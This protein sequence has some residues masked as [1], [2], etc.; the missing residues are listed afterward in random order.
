MNEQALQ[1]YEALY[2]EFPDKAEVHIAL[3]QIANQINTKNFAD[4]RMLFGTGQ[5]QSALDVLAKAEN[6]SSRY[7]WLDINTP[8]L[9]SGLRSEIQTAMAADYFAKA[10]DAVENEMWDQASTYIYKARR[11]GSDKA[12]LEYLELM[13]EIVPRYKKGLK[14]KELGLY[15]D[16]FFYF[17]EVAEIDADFDQ[18]LDHLEYC[19]ERAEMTLS[20]IHLLE[21]RGVKN[22]DKSIIASVQEEILELNNP[23]VRLVTR[24]DMDILLQEQ[25]NAMEAGFDDR[26]MIEAGLLLGAKYLIVGE[27]L[28]NKFE[29]DPL[30]KV[31]K[32]GYDGQTVLA[33]K[34]EY[35]ENSITSR[36]IVS[37]RYRVLNAET[38]EILAAENIPYKYE[39][40]VK[41]I[42]YNGDPSRLK[43]GDWKFK[44]FDSA[45]DRIFEEDPSESDL[46]ALAN[47]RKTP[48]SNQELEQKFIKY[49][50]EVI[51]SKVDAY[52]KNRSL[53]DPND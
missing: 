4:A 18:V 46:S 27:V 21:G 48:L 30:R 11:A 26:E 19:R 25:R 1:A 3:K 34:V 43:P 33:R 52:A 9:S 37:F 24:D 42:N 7:A 22:R 50:G 28:S 2:R 53:K 5:Y 17:Q 29:N 49:I 6:F 41:W 16:A 47:A 40:E 39:D 38:G 36:H 12:E 44:Y 10:Q 31:W 23:L 35:V 13:I 45:V 32:K 15:Q 20:Y 51:A 14:A 8:M